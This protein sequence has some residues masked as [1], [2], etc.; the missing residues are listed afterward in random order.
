MNEM[1][2]SFCK[3]MIHFLM[4]QERMSDVFRRKLHKN[5]GWNLYL[6]VLENL[7]LLQAKI[8]I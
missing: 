4:F 3:F 1:K 6:T 2:T 5:E 8:L 7:L